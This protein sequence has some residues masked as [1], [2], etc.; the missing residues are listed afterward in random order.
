LLA[1]IFV[2]VISLGACAHTEAPSGR[3]PVLV[4]PTRPPNCRKLGVVEGVGGRDETA[5]DNALAQ[6]SERGATHVVLGTPDLNI[7]SGITTVVDATLF[8]CLP[9]PADYPP[10]GYPQ[11][12][13]SP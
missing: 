11:S 10:V 4:V 7:T 13:G 5:I 9:A 8:D 2:S 6:A 3:S 12:S 1:V